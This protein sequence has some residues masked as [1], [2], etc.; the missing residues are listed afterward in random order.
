MSKT[1][2]QNVVTISTVASIKTF[3]DLSDKL[4]LLAFDRKNKQKPVKNRKP[5]PL[6]KIS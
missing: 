5:S 4:E 6:I 3:L 1:K 2:M